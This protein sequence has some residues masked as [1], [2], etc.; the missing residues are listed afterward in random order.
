MGNRKLNPSINVP[1]LTLWIVWI[2]FRASHESALG[3]N[4]VLVVFVDVVS[5]TGSSPRGSPPVGG[6]GSPPF[7][8]AAA[9]CLAADFIWAV[10]TCRKIAPR[11]PQQWRKAPTNIIMLFIAAARHVAIC[12]PALAVCGE[13]IDRG[14]E[15]NRS[16]TS[17]HL[18]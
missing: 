10:S 14:G 12:D 4:A 1:H 15:M 8:I 6:R 11:I 13:G 2:V 3:M 17:C 7:T 18:A 16:V 9:P 5:S